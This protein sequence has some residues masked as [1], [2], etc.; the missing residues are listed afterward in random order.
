MIIISI[1]SIIIIISII[2]SSSSS[3]S[4]SSIIIAKV[5]LIS[6]I[7][8]A[9][10]LILITLVECHYSTIAHQKSTP[11]KSSQMFSGMFQWIVSGSFQHHCH[12]SLVVSKGF[13][14]PV[15]CYWNLPMDVYWHFP[16]EFHLCKFWCVISSPE[17]RIS[18]IHDTAAGL[19][20][21]NP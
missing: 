4:S 7:A 15:D 11:Q 3:S 10:R 13:T 19:T 8:I 16:M 21:L 1:I 14:S 18:G 5:V 20:R 6:S 17:L 9:H 2:S 12:C